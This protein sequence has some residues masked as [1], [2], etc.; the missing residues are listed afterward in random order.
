MRPLDMARKKTMRVSYDTNHGVEWTTVAVQE[1]G[2]CDVIQLGDTM[3]GVST[4]WPIPDADW[5]GS[6]GHCARCGEE[7]AGD[8][9]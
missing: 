3:G 5:P 2:D 4:V 9:A 7:L 6:D 8:A 1:Y